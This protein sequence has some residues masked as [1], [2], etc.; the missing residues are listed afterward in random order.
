VA[1]ERW[2]KRIPDFRLDAAGK[3]R[4]SVGTVRGTRQLPILFGKEN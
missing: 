4:W 1:I 2:L 3:V